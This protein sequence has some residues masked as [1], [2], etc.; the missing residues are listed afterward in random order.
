MTK[1]NHL[2]TS[3][4]KAR[5]KKIGAK[6]DHSNLYFVGYVV[7]AVALAIIFQIFRW[8]VI[9][10][11]K[12]Q[13]LADSQY[14]SSG[15]QTATRG[16]I[17]AEDGTVLAV[18]QPTWNIYASLSNNV[19][20]R[21]EFFAQKDKYIQEVS[22]ILGLEKTDIE[23]KLPD[24]FVY[25]LLAKNVSTDKKNA[26]AQDNIF[27]DDTQGFGFYFEST[28]QRIYPNGS[29]AAN[30]LGF[31]GSDSNGDDIGQYGVQGYYYG[32]LK[33]SDGYT[34]EEKDSS[35][36]VILT[37]E[38]DPILPK[39]GKDFTLTIDS[40]IQ[41]KVEAALAQGVKDTRSKSGDVI[42]MD[43][44]T[45]AIIA[46]A[47]YPSYDP[48]EYWRVSEAWILKNRAVSDVYEYG[49]VEKPITTAI[50]LDA[51]TIKPDYTCDDATGSLDLY[52]ATGYDDLK[53]RYIY[54]WNKKPNGLLDIA[55]IFA[56]SNNP[57]A[58]QIGLTVDLPTFYSYLQK[59]GIGSFIGIGLQD[60][61]TSYLK[62]LDKWT[63]L[64]EITA[65]YGQGISA[66]SLQIISAMS[67][68]AN[69]GQRMRPYIISQISDNS[70]T[71][72]IQPQ[73]L[74]TPVS[75]EVAD[76]V[77]KAMDEGVQQGALGG[78]AEDLKSYKIAAKTGTAQIAKADGSG[79]EDDISNA[80]VIGF[81][82]YDDPKFIMIVKLEEPQ[83]SQFASYTSVPVWRSIFLAIKDDLEI[84]TAN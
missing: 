80:T 66:T 83:V 79:Y 9:D 25:V 35:G 33:G 12:L 69:G 17:V 5:G 53:G 45:G 26:L 75:K 59:F 22:S 65:S 52:K 64:D 81:A 1:L 76:I 30:I 24:D 82:P 84:Q 13:A 31:I 41:S 73:V 28:Q 61:S 14:Q 18:D 10:S 21:E 74:S 72:T 68:I 4:K 16:K 77:A 63:K 60:E 2:Y 11:G 23:S 71:I 67:A 51:G 37:S 47:N 56:K 70:E 6:K 3:Q 46:M 44:K 40:N 27:G 57:C 38:Y 19:A 54:T 55:G 8:Q 7:T 50:A 78:L 36:N 29:L 49:S 42:I 20:D 32:D 15:T 34:Y 58:A 48:S 43:P 62:P 39:E